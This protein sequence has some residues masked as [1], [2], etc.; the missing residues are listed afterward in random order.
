[1]FSLLW[2]VM[3]CLVRVFLYLRPLF[4]RKIFRK[5][6]LPIF[7]KNIAWLIIRQMMFLG[8]VQLSSG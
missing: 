8:L 3:R 1:M 6:R 2:Q 5:F 7:K 4:G